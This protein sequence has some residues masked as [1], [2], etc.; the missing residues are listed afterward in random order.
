MNIDRSI[1]GQV[2]RFRD[3]EKYSFVVDYP[4]PILR[5]QLNGVRVLEKPPVEVYIHIP[6]CPYI[7]DFCSFFKLRGMGEDQKERY[8]KV[9]EKEVAIY[10]EKSDLKLRNINSLFL[11]GGTPTTLSPK[12]FLHLI[13]YLRTNLNFADEIE[14][15]SESTPDTL[16]DEILEAMK[17]SGVNRL[18][19][20]VQDFNDEV[21]AARN[22]GHT[23]Q[24]AIDAFKKARFHG[25]NK[26]NIDLMYR[27]P[28]Q[29][30]ERWEYNL[31]IIG[32]LRPDYVTLYHLRKEKRTSLSRYDESI[33][34]SKEESMKMY[35]IALSFLV[36]LGYVQISPNQFA[37]PQEEFKQQEH[38]WHFGSELLGLGVSAYSWFNG[39]S[40]RNIGR[41]G[42]GIVQ[43]VED[44]MK[45]I[46]SGWLAIES[47][48]KISLK[49]QMHRF[50]VLAIKTSGINREDAGIDKR[51]FFERF[52]VPIQAV[53][54]ETLEDLKKKGLI[55][56]TDN[57]IR[58]TLRGLIVAE[59]VATMFYSEDVKRRL[60]ELDDPFGRNG[61]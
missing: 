8:V 30:L 2:A 21:L 46:E 13:N 29:S 51:L 7:C 57:F 28:K 9:V 38:K 44:Y 45:R 47:G 17:E 3:V 55:E 5:S 40:Y 20:G 42:M 12:Q 22:R 11:G 41:F 27:L 26:I 61:L 59:E 19:I 14:V 16:T 39:Y 43:S 50:A 25:F 23:G 4:P 54:G 18:S 1:I 36:G 37:L 48:E 60:R 53:F 33:F 35:L 49:E 58:L 24:Q 52:G 56:E 31:K 32:E 6:E 34:P 10:L 15:T